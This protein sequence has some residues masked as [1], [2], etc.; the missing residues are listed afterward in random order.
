MTPKKKERARSRYLS[1]HL[2]GK[3]CRSLCEGD[4]PGLR[5]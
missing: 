3:D 5:D 1:Q 2:G 4:Q